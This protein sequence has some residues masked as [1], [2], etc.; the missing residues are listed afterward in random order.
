MAANNEEAVVVF[1]FV[2]FRVYSRAKKTAV[3]KPPLLDKIR[4]PLQLSP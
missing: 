4:P 2:L 3:W 1:S